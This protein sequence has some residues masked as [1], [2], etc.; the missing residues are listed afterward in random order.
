MDFININE[1][2]IILNKVIDEYDFLEYKISFEKTN[3]QRYIG[4]NDYNINYS[5]S[6]LIYKNGRKV[7]LNYILLRELG[8]FIKCIDDYIIVEN[9]TDDTYKIFKLVKNRILKTK[10]DIKR[11][12]DYTSIGTVFC[13]LNNDIYKRYNYF[14]EI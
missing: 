14:Y 10:L 7:R 12:I 4:L 2:D 6:Y 3:L 11:M 9:N 8:S 5:N 13:C 1:K